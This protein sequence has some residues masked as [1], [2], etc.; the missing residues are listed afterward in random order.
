MRR[1][2]QTPVNSDKI[3]KITKRPALSRKCI[4]YVLNSCLTFQPEIRVQGSWNVV[5]LIEA[6]V[7]LGR[8]K[9]NSIMG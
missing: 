5:F 3:V 9:G 8:V 4:V 7:V 2:P 1:V 6:F